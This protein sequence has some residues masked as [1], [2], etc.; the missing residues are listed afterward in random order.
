MCDFMQKCYNSCS[1]RAGWPKG[2]LIMKGKRWCRFLEIGINGFLD[3]GPLQDSSQDWRYGDWA[4][5]CLLHRVR[6]FW[7][8]AKENA[9]TI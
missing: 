7:D 8:W 5:V 4:K 3:D 9:G 2:E 1:S 6:N